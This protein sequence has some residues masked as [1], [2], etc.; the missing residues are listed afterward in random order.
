M[1]KLGSGRGRILCTGSYKRFST[2]PFLW[3]PNS[4]RIRNSPILVSGR[5]SGIHSIRNGVGSAW[6]GE[7]WPTTEQHYNQFR[8][9]DD[10]ISRNFTENYTRISSRTEPCEIG[11]NE[12]IFARS[13]GSLAVKLYIEL[14]FTSNL[15]S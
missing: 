8:R 2:S 14:S 12:A 5:M 6:S 13:H 9:C 1:S 4:K 10:S 15:K 7:V 11:R 3:W